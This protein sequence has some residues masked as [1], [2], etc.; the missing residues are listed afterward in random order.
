MSSNNATI[1]IDLGD[2]RHAVCVL[3]AGGEILAEEMI[4]NT[5]ECLCAFAQ[6]HPGAVFVMGTGTHSPWVSRLLESLGHTVHVANVR[7]VRAI[8]TS[9]NK[10]DQEDAQ[11][12][13][14]LGRT[15]PALLSPVK[16]RNGPSAGSGRLKPYGVVDA[17]GSKHVAWRLRRFADRGRAG[18]SVPGSFARLRMT[19]RGARRERRRKRSRNPAA[20]TR[21]RRRAA[22]A[23]GL[24][25][26][27]RSS[28]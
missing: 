14:R 12:L 15:D 28:R 24:R 4:T 25:R 13:A 3:S 7:K 18:G 11:M 2:R 1:G 16:H 19:S 22:G 17:A 8:S 27:G 5:R 21:W 20:A 9:P 26:G 6:R 23:R 10:N